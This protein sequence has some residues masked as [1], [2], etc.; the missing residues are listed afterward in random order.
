MALFW[1][2]YIIYG[3]VS[4]LY[5][6]VRTSEK[7][8]KKQ[9][10]TLKSS[11]WGPVLGFCFNGFIPLCVSTQLAI[12][13]SSFTTSG[14]VIAMIWMTFHACILYIWFPYTMIRVIM[15]PKEK[16]LEPEFKGKYGFL[17]NAINQDTRG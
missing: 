13:Y 3:Y 10:A 11:K 17:F 1:A 16:L 5:L 8:L 7:V 9:Q 6:R 15:V 4:R 12:R 14:E 2:K